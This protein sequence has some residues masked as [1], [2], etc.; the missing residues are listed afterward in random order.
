MVD[1]VAYIFLCIQL[2][3]QKVE[4][5]SDMIV[6]RTAEICTNTPTIPTPVLPCDIITIYI[7]HTVTYFLVESGFTEGHYV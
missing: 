3:D 2:Q 4:I 6:Y 5:K 7:N 1:Y